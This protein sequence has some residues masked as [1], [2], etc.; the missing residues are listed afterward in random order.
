MSQSQPKPQTDLLILSDDVN[1]QTGLARITRE[2]ATR[3]ATKLPQFRVGTTSVGGKVNRS[4]PFPQF[5][6]PM[7]KQDGDEVRL[8]KAWDAFHASTSDSPGVL[9]T[10]W[11]PGWLD[12]LATPEM[13]PGDSVLRHFLSCK[14]FKKWGYFPIDGV[15]P[16]GGLPEEVT[17][18]TD[19]FD[20]R[21]T[22]TAWA[23]NLLGCDHLPHGLDTSVFYPRD[24]AEARRNLISRAVG[25]DILVP[26]DMLLVGVVATNTARKDWWLAFETVAELAKRGHKVGLWCHTDSVIKFW[27]LQQLTREFGLAGK[28]MISARE[29]SSSELAWCY[30]ACDVTLGIGSGEGWGYPLAES[31]ACGV[32][33]IHG[34]YAGGTEIVVPGM[35][36]EPIAWRGDGPY[37]IKR[38]VF[39]AEDWADKVEAWKGCAVQLPASLDWDSAWRRWEKWLLEGIS[40]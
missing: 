36:V 15:G 33:V 11:N 23:G 31:S 6:M 38:P 40:E 28:V 26:D 21:L 14:P 12:W 24:R 18:I 5:P 29:M 1:S 37:S 2:L 27:N 17:N 8:Y 34:N 30:S 9:L 20:R 13:L 35:R 16:G 7:P 19:T 39:G 3:I 4:L 25:E 22:Y 32:P 10:I